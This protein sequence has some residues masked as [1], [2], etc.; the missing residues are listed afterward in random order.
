[1][2][3]QTLSVLWCFVC[4]CANICHHLQTVATRTV[5]FPYNWQVEYSGMHRYTGFYVVIDHTSSCRYVEYV[6]FVLSA[7][8]SA[9][10]HTQIFQ[11]SGSLPIS[12]IWCWHLLQHLQVANASLNFLK[13]LIHLHGYI[14]R[15]LAI[16]QL[17]IHFFSSSYRR[18]RF[19][20][21]S[22]GS[23]TAAFLVSSW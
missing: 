19:H 16:F 20:Q 13:D 21:R 2:I 18:S 23:H 1:M 8:L 17:I 7:A 22:R 6:L 15:T 14:F 12:S 3:Q 9:E 11:A 10:E 5:R 4:V